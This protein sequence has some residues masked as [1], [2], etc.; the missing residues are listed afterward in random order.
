MRENLWVRVLD[1]NEGKSLTEREDE[2]C[3]V[4]V[5]ELSTNKQHTLSEVNNPSPL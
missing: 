5:T 2:N 1:C 4:E 3:G